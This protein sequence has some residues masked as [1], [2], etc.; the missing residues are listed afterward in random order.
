MWLDERVLKAF[1]ATHPCPPKEGM[2]P[3]AE[4]MI[5]GYSIKCNK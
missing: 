1:A 2:L 4:L 3:R 5:E